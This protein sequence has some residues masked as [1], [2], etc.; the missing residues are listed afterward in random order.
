[1][2]DVLIIGAGP[3]G[4]TAAIYALRAGLS[5]VICEKN[6]YGGQTAIID[7]IENYPGIKKISG[8]DFSSKL[9]E[10][11]VALGAKFIFDEV[12]KVDFVSNN[13]LKEVNLKSSESITAKTVIIANGLKRR[14][15]GCK[16]EE[17]FFGRGVSYCASCDGAFFKGK[18]VAVVG[19]GNTALEDAIYLSNICSKVTMIVRKDH[20][21]GEKILSDVVKNIKNIEIKFN[22][23]IQEISG[24]KKVEKITILKNIDET[25]DEAIDGVFI[26]IGY[27]PD[28]DLYKGQ[29]EMNESGYFK[30]D[31]TCCTNVE[32][33]YV[34]GDCREKQLRQ[35]VTAVS[36]GAIAGN[37]AISYILSHKF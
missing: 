4:I 32:G 6:V 22:S 11:V 21:R 5:V 24:D 19:G 36:D 18:K 2:V 35:I 20:F 15:L 33:V 25:Y 27:S 14:K 17:K 37:R 12:T 34:A 30:S 26:A 13:D 3:A 10:Q 8:A 16:G 28:N 9:Y 7:E 23:N 29:I 31:E 1:M